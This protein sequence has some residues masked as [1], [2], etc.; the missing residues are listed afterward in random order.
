MGK[1]LSRYIEEI[2]G[3]QVT[4]KVLKPHKKAKNFNKKR[5]TAK[6]PEC[7]SNLYVDEVGALD[8]DGSLLKTWENLCKVYHEADDQAKDQIMNTLSDKDKFQELYWRWAVSIESG[9]TGLTH[10]GYTNR[11]YPPIASNKSRLPDPLF[12]KRIERQL[13]RNLTEEEILG[14]VDLWYYKGQYLTKW[15]KN[16]KKVVIPIITIPDEV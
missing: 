4:V 7:G 6:C 2:N 8:C 15:R 11:L 10:C 13:G 5:A 3:Q 16:A 9:G 14:E 12:T 1:K